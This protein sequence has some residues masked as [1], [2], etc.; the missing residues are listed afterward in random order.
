MEN[1]KKRKDIKPYELLCTHW[2]SVKL[3]TLAS[4]NPQLIDARHGNVSNLTA[5]K[6]YLTNCTY[7]LM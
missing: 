2:E 6:Q 4:K 7:F 5:F 3:K 1:C